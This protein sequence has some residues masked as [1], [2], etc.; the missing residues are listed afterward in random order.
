[1]SNP[2]GLPD[3]VFVERDAAT[4]SA[5][6]LS[7]VETEMG[8]TLAP[9]D[10]RRKVI[11]GVML[12]LMQERQ[13][14]NITGRQNLLPYSTGD[15]LLAIGDLVLGDESDF[16]P[17]SKALTTI[18]FTLSGPRASATPIASGK[19]I[20]AGSVLFET[21]DPIEI[22]IG[23][24][25]GDVTARA[26][27]A[28]EEA[29][30][31][32][33]GQINSLVEPIPYVAS[34]VNITTSQGGAPEE[35]ED[36][37][38]ARVREKPA[39]FSVAGP[40]GA[41]RY[42]AKTASTA[43]S[44][45]SVMTSEASPGEVFVY[46]LLVDGQI[47]GS[48]ILAL[49]LSALSDKTKR[50]LTDLVHSSAPTGVACNVTFSYWIDSDDAARAETIKAAV[51]A[52]VTEYRSWQR[53]KLGRDINPDKLR[54]LVIAAGAKRMTVS[55]PAFQSLTLVQVAQDG[56]VAVTYGGLEDA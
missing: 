16:L 37:Y 45:V 55:S 47:P 32:L 12:L 35:T 30:D 40:E 10:P 20:A 18:R 33:A 53:G 29:N 44:D 52:A 41:Y 36:A 46:S 1:M 11:N 17:A 15:A 31:F 38:R 49:V 50:P 28:G 24:T 4:V 19:L 3:L 34:A 13:N 51:D 23:A 43:I 48:E 8:I 6:M 27:V 2:S 26:M 56:T 9:G 22:A 54:S 25:T 5:S 21:L 39:A 14:L 7:I 42:W